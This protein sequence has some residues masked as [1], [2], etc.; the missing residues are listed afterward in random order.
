[1][2]II[3]ALAFLVAYLQHDHY[4]AIIL[5]AA[6]LARGQFLKYHDSDDLMYPHCLETM[7]GPLAAEPRAGFALSTYA[8]NSLEVYIGSLRRKTEAE[9]E[10]RLIQTVRGVGYRFAWGDGSST[11]AQTIRSLQ[12]AKSVPPP[13]QPV[14][15]TVKVRE[16]L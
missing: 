11:S 15:V 1:M 12:S 6:T 14:T 10:P 13:T 4:V 16:T 2:Q 8:S 7:L 5:R 3:F 9:G